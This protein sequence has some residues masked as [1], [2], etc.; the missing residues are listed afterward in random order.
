MDATLFCGY[1]QASGSCGRGHPE[2]EEYPAAFDWRDS[3]PSRAAF[4]VWL[5]T[6]VDGKNNGAPVVPFRVLK[7]FDLALQSWLKTHLGPE[8]SA[9]TVRATPVAQLRDSRIADCLTRPPLSV[10]N[11]LSLDRLSLLEQRRA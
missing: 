11:V 6:T 3:G 10:H 9:S 4:R 8:Y 7:P 5:N 2:A 1:R